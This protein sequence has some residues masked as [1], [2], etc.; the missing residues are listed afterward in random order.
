MSSDKGSVVPPGS[1]REI[2]NAINL[3]IAYLIQ[4]AYNIPVSPDV[5]ERGYRSD[6]EWLHQRDVKLNRTLSRDIEIVEGPKGEGLSFF[7]DY[8]N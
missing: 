5:V 4:D 3:D 1:K 2:V 7:R 6:L 8:K